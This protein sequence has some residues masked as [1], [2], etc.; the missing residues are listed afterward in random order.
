MCC[1]YVDLCS[2]DGSQVLLE[3]QARSASKIR[4][5]AMIDHEWSSNFF[6]IKGQKHLSFWVHDIFSQMRRN[7]HDDTMRGSCF[8]CILYRF[9]PWIFLLPGARDCGKQQLAVDCAS[10]VWRG[11]SK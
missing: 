10:L 6:K 11:G 7:L 9:F 3:C 4:L 1:F 2:L 8:P 5:L